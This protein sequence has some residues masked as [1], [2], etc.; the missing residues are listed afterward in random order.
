MGEK[1]I[2]KQ[3][4]F[5]SSCLK[6]FFIFYFIIKLY[7]SWN[8]MRMSMKRYRARTHIIGWIRIENLHLLTYT[9]HGKMQIEPPRLR[10]R[11]RPRIIWLLPVSR[12][13]PIVI[14]RQSVQRWC[15]R[16]HY[17]LHKNGGRPLI[18]LTCAKS[19]SYYNN[20]VLWI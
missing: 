15:V 13:Q 20:I 12:L 18:S 6:C 14:A 17:V 1:K 5:M 4:V 9:L 19:L 2:S 7:L 16:L 3:C 10:V 8:Q 11:V